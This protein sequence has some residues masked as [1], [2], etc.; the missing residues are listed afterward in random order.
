LVGA[1]G[2]AVLGA[3][4]DYWLDAIEDE[5]WIGAG[6][7]ATMGERLGGGKPQK[8]LGYQIVRKEK[9]V[10]KVE[11][12][13]RPTPPQYTVWSSSPYDRSGYVS[14]ARQYGMLADPQV[15]RDISPRRVE[16]Y[17]ADMRAGHWRYL[18]SDPITITADGHVVNG[19]HRLAAVSQVDWSKVEND[20]KFLVV[21][22]VDPMEAI[23]ADTSAKRTAKDQ[24][25][26]SAKVLAAVS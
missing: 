16:Q 4:D 19:Q 22:G 20:P 11:F 17:C 24:S 13:K 3:D 8:P 7:R 21:F 14:H 26:I 23:L 12:V 25:T 6:V 5:G 9:G 1:V 2:A 18:L 10:T 15:N